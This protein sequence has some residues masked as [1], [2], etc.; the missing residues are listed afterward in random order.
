MYTFFP[1]F[2]V[3]P[4]NA[5]A[6][7]INNPQSTPSRLNCK[8]TGGYYTNLYFG[9]KTA[10]KI[11]WS[12][13]L[14]LDEPKGVVLFTSGERQELIKAIYGA[15][16]VQ[17]PFEHIGQKKTVIINRETLGFTM[18]YRDDTIDSTDVGVCSR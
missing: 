18:K 14:V 11:L 5:S 9:D 6:S 16:R 1:L 7:F 17:F 4:L 15:N 3:S 2:L 8:F 12:F 10:S 13:G